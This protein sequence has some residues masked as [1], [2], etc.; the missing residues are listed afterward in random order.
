MVLTLE[1]IQRDPPQVA[2][3][4]AAV[5]QAPRHKRALLAHQVKAR[6][7]ATG[8][9]VVVRLRVVAA[10]ARQPQE[11]TAQNLALVARAVLVRPGT[12]LPTL[13]AVAVVN[14]TSRPDLMAALVVAVKARQVTNPQARGEKTLAV[15]GAAVAA[16]S[17]CQQQVARASSSFVTPSRR[18]CGIFR[19]T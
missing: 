10:G 18:P 15:A 5:A 12:A 16:L 19:A 4:V 1:Q 6:Q 17:T 8:L 13:V 9:W 14:E 3:A 11:A 7:V 2:L